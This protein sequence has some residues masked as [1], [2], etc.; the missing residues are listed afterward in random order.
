VARISPPATEPWTAKL[1]NLFL[2]RRFGK[3]FPSVKLLAHHPRYPFAYGVLSSTFG[4]AKTKLPQ[5]IKRLATQLVAELNGCAFCIDLGLR[6]AQDEKLNVEKLKYVLE[7]ETRLL[8]TPSERAALKYAYEATQVGA[9]VSDETFAELKKYFSER[10]IL[11]LTVAVATENF[12]NRLNA[13]LEVESQ[14]FC[15]VL[16][17]RVQQT[18]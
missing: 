18:A 15:N 5:D 17:T 3:P 11:E 4:L 1:L 16:M 7:F 14:G 12:Y 2:T 8:Y 9:R 6:F 13:P 10:E